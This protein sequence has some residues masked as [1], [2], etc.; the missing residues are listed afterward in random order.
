MSVCTLLA[1]SKFTATDFSSDPGGTDDVVDE[2]VP[3]PPPEPVDPV[4]KTKIVTATRATTP[5]AAI[6][7]MIG[8][9]R[10]GLADGGS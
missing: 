4:A 10:E 8:V 1:A 3:F 5:R 7:R 6:P 9:R 2:A